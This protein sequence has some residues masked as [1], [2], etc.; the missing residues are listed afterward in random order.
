M[1]KTGVILKA[2]GGAIAT[3]LTILS[4][5]RENPQISEGINSAIDKIR[6]ATN[7]ENPKLRFDAKLKAVE[8]CADAVEENFPDAAE[9]PLWRVTTKALRMR[10]ELAWSANHGRA[11]TRAIK[12][13][14]AE[15]TE[16]LQTV[17]ARLL[18]LSGH[19]PTVEA[20]GEATGSDES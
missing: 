12:A 19:G 6:A 2:A 17:N 20:P 15:A 14:T 13:L 7:S 11:R 10:G 1:S 3:T 16:V 5:L 8:A 9:P 18:D 4:A